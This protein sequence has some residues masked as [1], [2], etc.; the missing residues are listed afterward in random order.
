MIFQSA[1]LCSDYY[2]AGQMQKDL[3]PH[4]P[5]GIKFS[6]H[7]TQ[8]PQLLLQKHQSKIKTE[9]SALAALFAATL[10]VDTA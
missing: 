1:S 2:F 7:Q 8:M 9:L 10:V 3:A 5:L 4:H 6:F